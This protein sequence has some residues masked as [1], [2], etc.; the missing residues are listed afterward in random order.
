MN[1]QN[2]LVCPI[3]HPNIQSEHTIKRSQE[4]LIRVSRSCW[5]GR[6]SYDSM[7]SFANLSVKSIK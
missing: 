7:N 1:D 3:P 6:I 4:M 5:H 2:I